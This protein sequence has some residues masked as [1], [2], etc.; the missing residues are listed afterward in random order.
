MN[1]RFDKHDN[2]RLAALWDL[3]AN[4]DIEAFATLYK[5]FYPKLY[6]YGLKFVLDV[7]Q[8]RDVIQELFTKLYAKPGLVTNADTLQAFLF[9]SFRNACL[10]LAGQA[11]RRV[12]IQQFFD[13]DFLFEV[14]ADSFEV[15]EAEEENR[16]QIERILSGLT[17]RQRKIIYLRF[18]DQLEYDEIARIMNLSVQAARNL[19]HRAIKQARKTY[20]P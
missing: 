16:R 1:R 13:F 6:T 7:E 8:V 10:N 19:I 4:G 3:F 14:D 5:W 20:K 15:R 12:D 2:R 9:A 11:Y 17:P 18:M